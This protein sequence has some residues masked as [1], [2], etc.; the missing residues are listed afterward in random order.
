MSESIPSK[1]AFYIFSNG[2]LKRKENT[3]FFIPSPNQDEK[4]IL[5]SPHEEPTEEEEFN[6]ELDTEE[7]PYHP[8]RKAI[9]IANI[10]A[11]YIFGEVGFNMR[12]MNF[13]SQHHIPMHLFNYYGYYSGTYY[14][15][16]YLLSGAMLVN[17][18]THYSSDKKRLFLAREF[19]KAA[20]FNI[21]KN[22]KHYAA[23]SRQP[24]K[25]TQDNLQSLISMIDGYVE[26]IPAAGDIPTLMGLE[27]NIRQR[28][29]SAW[30]LLIKSKD[31]AFEFKERTKNPPSNAVNALISFANAL[32]YSACLTELYRTQLNPT[33]AYL[34]EPG[35]RRFS[36]ALDVAE[37]FKPIFADRVIF[38]LIN[39]QQIQEKHFT[40]KLNFCHLND[41]GR[42]IVVKE[43]EE[44]LRTTIKHRTLDRNVSYRRLIRLECYKLIKHLLNEQPYEAFKIWW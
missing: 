2:I 17:Q 14:P 26:T 41:A 37:I 7:I 11:F 3:I 28:Y 30:Q 6:L 42:K 5:T 38:K 34:H 19:V 33:I 16:E 4:T 10:D 27:G 1:Q 25:M 35:S 20:A 39:T 15:R 29:Y 43:F 23:E 9:P 21:Q 22:L 36:L 40:Q 8:N 44:K 24:D 32:C 12:F 31:Q 13:L 18:V